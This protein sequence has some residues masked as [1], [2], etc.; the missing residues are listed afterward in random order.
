MPKPSQLPRGLRNNNP[1]N[2]V[3]SGIPWRGKIANGTDPTFE[4]FSSLAYGVR[5]AL[6]NLRGYI[7][8]HYVDTPLTIIHRWSPDGEKLEASYL[9]AVCYKGGFKEHERIKWAN[10]NQVCRLVWAMAYVECGQEIP[11]GVVENAYS[12]IANGK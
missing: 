12:M 8:R 5:A 2:I 11:F 9:R 6:L 7:T 4:Q 10:K 3:K 1:L